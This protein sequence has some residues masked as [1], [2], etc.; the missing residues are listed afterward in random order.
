VRSMPREQSKPT[1]TV[2][3]KGPVQANFRASWTYDTT[4]IK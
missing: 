4:K 2:F 3:L 1:R